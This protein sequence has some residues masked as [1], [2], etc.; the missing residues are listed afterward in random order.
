M[1][2][3]YQQL[4]QQMLNQNSLPSS[5]LNNNLKQ[6]IMNIKNNPNPQQFLF[7]YIQSNPQAQNIYNVLQNSNKSPKELFYQLA[8]QKGVDPNTILQLLQ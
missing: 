2:S 6:F 3:L 1:N 8:S 5:S 4:N 7:N